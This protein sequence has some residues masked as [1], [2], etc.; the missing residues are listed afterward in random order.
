MLWKKNKGLII[1]LLFIVIC[2]AFIIKFFFTERA[3]VKKVMHILSHS[4]MNWLMA[5]IGLCLLQVFWQGMMYVFSFRAIGAS[6]KIT[7]AIALYLKRD[8]AGV[9]I[10]AG[11]LTS[12]GLFT[13]RLEEKGIT[14]EQ[15][16]AASSIYGFCGM[17]TVAI[18][19]IP[20]LGYLSLH[21][22]VL[23]SELAA[24]A[25]LLALMAAIVAAAV[26]ALRKGAVYRLLIKVVPTLAQHTE[27][28]SHFTF[29]K[30]QFLLA[31]SF[32]MLV[33]ATGIGF[34][35]TAMHAA[36][37]APS[38]QLA[39]IGYAVAIL[40]YTISPFMDGTGAVEII[41]TYVLKSS[42]YIVSQAIS[43]TLLFR[44]FQF[45]FIVLLGIPPLLTGLRRLKKK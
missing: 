27:R 19:A 29:N 43:V 37:A 23:K 28:I 32:S 14:N 30:T 10:P 5:G 13:K 7:D 2:L 31:L 38:L 39:V 1:Q 12:L 18:I 33:E 3:E 41:L 26:S 36:G 21:S 35:Y 16:Y 42:G 22:T 24:M 34:L 17:A 6:I 40:V 25:G 4:N 44:F 11:G 9:F 45:W 8:T 20:V 15:A